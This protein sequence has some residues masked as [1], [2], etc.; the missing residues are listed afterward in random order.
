M[1]SI[2][3]YCREARVNEDI[4]ERI[5]TYGLKADHLKFEQAVLQYII[6]IWEGLGERLDIRKWLRKAFKAINII[7]DSLKSAFPQLD[8]VKQFKDHFLNLSE[9]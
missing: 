3:R 4:R 5:R 6:G 9:D 2:I 1:R 7:I 8:A